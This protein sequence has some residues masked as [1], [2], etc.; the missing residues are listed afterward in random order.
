MSDNEP[1]R[2]T[3]SH[4][5][6]CYCPQCLSADKLEPWPLRLT[7][8]EVMTIKAALH[9]AI[10]F[11]LDFRPRVDDSP[12]ELLTKRA[13]KYRLALYAMD[14]CF[15]IPC[16]EVSPNGENLPRSEAE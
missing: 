9:D 4:D 1:A 12:Q 5:G 2:P 16:R 14:R 6:Q 10:D 11:T 13:E 7:T 3:G 8:E 15:I